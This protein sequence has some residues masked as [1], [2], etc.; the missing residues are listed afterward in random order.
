MWTSVAL[1]R[2]T[3]IYALVQHSPAIYRIDL[4]YKLTIAERIG[5]GSCDP[6]HVH[7]VEWMDQ[8][9]VQCHHDNDAGDDDDD[10]VE[11]DAYK[12]DADNRHDATSYDDDVHVDSDDNDDGD[13]NDDGGDNDNGDDYDGGGLGTYEG[14]SSS[15]VK[16]QSRKKSQQKIKNKQLSTKGSYDVGASRHGWKDADDGHDDDHDSPNY[17]NYDDVAAPVNDCN[18]HDDDGCADGSDDDDGAMYYGL[19]VLIVEHAA[20]DVHHHATSLK[21]IL[22]GRCSGKN[23]QNKKTSN[24]NLF[25]SPM[26]SSRFEKN[27]NDQLVIDVEVDSNTNDSTNNVIKN[28]PNNISNFIHNEERRQQQPLLKHKPFNY[29]HSTPLS[30]QQNP[31][32]KTTFA[33]FQRQQQATNNKNFKIFYPQS[34]DFLATWKHLYVYNSSDQSLYEMTLQKYHDDETFAT[35][36]IIQNDNNKIF[37]KYDEDERNDSPHRKVVTKLKNLEVSDGIKKV[38]DFSEHACIPSQLHHII[39]GGKILVECLEVE[40]L[41]LFASLKQNQQPESFE[42]EYSTENANKSTNTFKERQ[43]HKRKHQ[44]RHTHARTRYKYLS[45]DVITQQA[46]D[47][48]STML[49]SSGYQLSPDCR[50]LVGLSDDMSSFIAYRVTM[51]DLKKCTP[52][53]LQMF[54]YANA[55]SQYKFIKQTSRTLNEVVHTA[56]MNFVMTSMAF[57]RSSRSNNVQNHL[58][59]LQTDDDKY[60]HAIHEDVPT[61]YDVVVSCA[62]E[63][64]LKFQM[65]SPDV[66][67]ISKSF[68]RGTSSQEKSQNKEE[69]SL[70]SGDHG[71]FI[72]RSLKNGG[73]SVVDLGREVIKCNWP[74]IK[75]D[76]YVWVTSNYF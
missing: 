44:Q 36:Q 16:G 63:E 56:V 11:E 39:F 61:Q 66:T 47:L 26:D 12:N 27:V 53:N 34:N 28:I 3:F 69:L 64:M 74:N 51:N 41:P 37:D 50:L 45:Y 23:G 70:D 31:H 65:D 52:H 67:I 62:G 71:N 60:E 22:T 7:Y 54:A 20:V 5:T 14:K 35:T 19:K 48:T 2:N 55:G 29:S 38:L 18:D 17:H 59:N 15:K 46:D 13:N 1:V 40:N 42:E 6:V 10:G 43:Q 21:R 30:R 68:K 75:I 57:V 58:N 76:H 8:L 33:R 4:R 73:L 25:S 24:R 32:H 49:Q 9:W 72:M